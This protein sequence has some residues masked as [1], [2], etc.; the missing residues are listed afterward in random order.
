MSNLPDRPGTSAAVAAFLRKVENLPQARPASG[1]RGR[2]VFA[3]DA[4]ASRQP[5][6]DRACQLQGEMFLATQDLGGLSVQL[7]YYRGFLE[8]AATPFL[9]DAMELTRRMTGVRCLGGQ[10]QIQRVLDHT[11]AETRKERVNALVFV[12]DAV[13]EPVDPLCHA[14][15]QLG[16]HGTP[17]FCFH[18]GGDHRAAQALKQLAQVSGGAYGIF[19][20]ASAEA[21]RALLRAVAVY[22][23]GGRAALTRLPGQVAAK[24]AGQLPAP[25]R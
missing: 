4:T 1:R 2:L 3:I 21:L 11:L 17:V 15:G 6:W 13:E 5:S 23:A 14:A 10:T 8:F 19:D 25:K 20:A 9:E 24:L 12:G 16:L 7:A 22:A 18:E